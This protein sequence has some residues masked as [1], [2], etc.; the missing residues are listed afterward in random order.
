MR[1]LILVAVLFAACTAKEAKVIGTIERLDPALDALVNKDAAIEVL[2]EGYEWSEGPVWIEK[3]N[4]L[5][6]SDVPKN[7]VYKWTEGH[8]AEVY[9]TPSGFTGTTTTS[10]EPG[11][12]GLVYYNDSLFLCQHGDRRI[13]RMNA[14]LHTPAA[15]FTTLA[16]TFN[17]KRFSSPNDAVMNSNGELFFTDPPYGLAKHEND[18]EKEQ[19]YNGVY[20]VTKGVVSLLVDS[21]TKPNGIIVMP[22]QKKIIVANS[23]PE[24]A[25]WY[26]F[27]LAE[28]G[29]VSKGRIFYDATRNLATDKGVPDGLKVDRAGNIYAS[30]PGGIWIF[31]SAGTVLGK[32]RLSELV[33]NCALSHDEKTLYITA[34]MYLLRIKLRK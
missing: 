16:A 15:T 20:K 14:P 23:D 12:N 17:E 11:A 9:L 28:D 34:D 6:F 32:I 10:N 5:L 7:I 4:M 2:A 25:T 31:N 33:S 19:P 27:E 8:G 21:L 24:K 18:S 13:A 1:N 29:T 3:E 22:D 30:G 26:E